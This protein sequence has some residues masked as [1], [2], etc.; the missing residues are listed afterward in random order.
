MNGALCMQ[1]RHVKEIPVD[2][3]LLQ[4]G[5]KNFG[6]HRVR[7]KG[8]PSHVPPSWLVPQPSIRSMDQHAAGK[9]VCQNRLIF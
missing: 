2:A 8:L 3:S 4:G 9:Q 5:A 1:A 6:T 7:R